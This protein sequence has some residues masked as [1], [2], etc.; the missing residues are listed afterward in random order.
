MKMTTASR[1]AM[2]GRFARRDLITILHYVNRGAR[3][4]RCID[5]SFAAPEVHLDRLAAAA[6]MQ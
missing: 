3:S 4:Q 2:T 6:R 1:L 5:G